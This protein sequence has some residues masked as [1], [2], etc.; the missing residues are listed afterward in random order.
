MPRVVID[1]ETERARRLGSRRHTYAELQDGVLCVM[2]PAP[3]ERLK[4]TAAQARFWRD[5]LDNFIPALEAEEAR[6]AQ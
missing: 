4:L 2:F 6:G 1:L 5:M 3:V